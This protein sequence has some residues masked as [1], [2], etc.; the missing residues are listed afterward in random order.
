M[1]RAGAA[2]SLGLRISAILAFRG[3]GGLG[4]GGGLGLRGGL[5]IGRGLLDPAVTAAGAATGGGGGGAVLARRGGGGIGGERPWVAPGEH[6]QG[7]GGNA[8]KG[9]VLHRSTPRPGDEP[10]CRATG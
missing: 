3:G 5:R 9:M 10:C 2:V 1:M 8:R 4:T 6:Q 7:D